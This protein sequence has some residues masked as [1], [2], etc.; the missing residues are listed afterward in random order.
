M[1]LQLLG[2]TA[3]AVVTLTVLTGVAVEAGRALA[4]EVLEVERRSTLAVVHARLVAARVRTASTNQRQRV[5]QVRVHFRYHRHSG[6]I[7]QVAF[8]EVGA[9]ALLCR[10]DLSAKH[11][12][13]QAMIQCAPLHW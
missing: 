1:S 2:A 11:Q 6:A 9:D 10:R 8:D 7:G 12:Q 13:Q 4:G 5:G 3:A